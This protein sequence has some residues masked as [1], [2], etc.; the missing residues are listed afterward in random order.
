MADAGR[1]V[2]D[3]FQFTIEQ[4]AA[5]GTVIDTAPIGLP[6]KD[7][8]VT[9]DPVNVVIDR[10]DGVRG[11]SENASYNDSTNSIARA[12]FK[13]PAT[14]LLLKTLVPGL[15][16]KNVAYTDSSGVWTFIPQAIADLPT[17]RDDTDAGYFYTITRRSPTA[18]NSTRIHNAI[19]TTMK[20][21]LDHA[22]DDGL[23]MIECEF[24]APAS[25]YSIVANPSGTVTQASLASV[26]Q[27]I[28][29]INGLD[30]ISLNSQSH[31]LGD[32]MS[33]EL[34]PTWNAKFQGD[35]PAGEVVFPRFECTGSIKIAGNSYTEALKVLCRT[36]A[37]ASQVD[38]QID[39]GDGT[40]SSA[41]EL[42]L[43]SHLK[44][45]SYTDPPELEDGEIITFNFNGEWGG[46]G[47]YP[48]SCI[49]H[50]A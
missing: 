48:F 23:L 18:S 26:Y 30:T 1:K 17:P 12:R 28:G 3:D 46:A 50:Y 40:V 37:V 22:S 45:M 20:L 10:A 44:M 21:M 35:N 38:L 19:M 36:A 41:G 5:W 34:N 15:L 4:Q 31:A 39:W 32:I 8:E 6:T 14:P 11:T 43:K 9:L 29:G 7:L 42:Q 47:E 16:Q 25:T 24:I 13:C 33:F 27:Y 2:I 49:V